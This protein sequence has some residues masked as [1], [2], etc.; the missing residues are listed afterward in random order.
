MKRFLAVILCALALFALAS[1]STPEQRVEKYVKDNKSL[2]LDSGYVYCEV[3]LEARGTDVVYKITIDGDID[4]TY[5]HEIIK[6]YRKMLDDEFERMYKSM[7]NEESAI[8]SLIV[9]ICDYEG[10]VVVGYVYK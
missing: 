8:T 7:K 10:N 3:D 5:T 4:E 9:E 2:G 1:C 6:E